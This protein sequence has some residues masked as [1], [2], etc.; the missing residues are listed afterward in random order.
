MRQGEYYKEK[1]RYLSIEA[2][3]SLPLLLD[4]A[5]VGRNKLADVFCWQQ[6]C[7]KPIC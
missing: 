6:I 5:F 1:G 4:P 2:Y 7:G 3:K